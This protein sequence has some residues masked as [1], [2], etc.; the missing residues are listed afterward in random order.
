MLPNRKGKNISECGVVLMIKEK[1]ILIS[2]FIAVCA[3]SSCSTQKSDDPV[4]NAQVALLDTSTNASVEYLRIKHHM[5]ECEGHHV[6]HCLLVQKEGNDQWQYFYDRIEG[7]DFSWGSNYEILVEVQQID[8]ALADASHQRYSLLEIIDEQKHDST[9]AF[10]YKTR[11]SNE[12]IIEKESG[13]FSLLGNKDFV[14]T[15]EVCDQVRSTII[16]NQSAVLSFQY[17]ADA[18]K[19]LVLTAVLCSD[20][21][22]SF[23]QSCL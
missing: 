12:R 20:A 7:F 10:N 4:A 17:S 16:Q 22:A 6:S 8:P 21:E 19:S 5:V 14:C 13:R 3:L 11:K 9:D 2:V 23:A 1:L 15:S 18:D